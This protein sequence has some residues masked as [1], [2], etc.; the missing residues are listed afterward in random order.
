MKSIKEIYELHDALTND[1]AK[2]TENT[3]IG[4]VL[5]G[6]SKEFKDIYSKYVQLLP[7]ALK[8]M[9]GEMDEFLK[10][11]LHDCSSD[12]AVFLKFLSLLHTPFQRRR[13][14]FNSL[15][16]VLQLIPYDHP[17]HQ[18]VL[19]SWKSYKITVSVLGE[20]LTQS[21]SLEELFTLQSQVVNYQVN[22]IIFIIKGPPL[23]EFGSILLKG[24]FTANRGSF[25][26]P[27][28]VYLL[29]KCIIVLK[30]KKSF[31]GR[32]KLSEF[33]IKSNSAGEITLDKL[34]ILDK[35]HI[36]TV[37]SWDMYDGIILLIINFRKCFSNCLCR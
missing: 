10:S 37:C 34:I 31:R 4:E 15:R 23:S 25:R 11:R 22:Q 20:I 19:A 26:K 21:E 6:Y 35:D 33:A 5:I 3:K 13:D 16:K 32:R 1:L 7:K 36:R 30:G 9:S 18:S 28:F 2:I 27:R 8:M 14:I 12:F 29:Q 24:N 17:D